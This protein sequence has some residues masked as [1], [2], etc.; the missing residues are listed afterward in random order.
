MKKMGFIFALVCFVATSLIIGCGEKEPAQQPAQKQEGKVE[1]QQDPM[2]EY[3]T[4]AEAKLEELGR[5]IE[6]LKQK[7]GEVKEDA[8]AE[9]NQQM[10]N[11]KEQQDTAKKKLE[12]LKTATREN[13]EDLKAQMDGQ[14]KKL[15]D[16][17]EQIKSKFQEG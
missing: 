15:G 12:E 1:Q 5:E 6:A 2:K 16:L 17:F 9:F 10:D 13:W 8:K 3:Q 4:M 11:L 14:L 7:A